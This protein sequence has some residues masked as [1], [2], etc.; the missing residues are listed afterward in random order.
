MSDTPELV[1]FNIKLD[2]T[3]RT[4][5][6]AIAKYNDTD[7][8]KLVRQFMKKYVSDNANLVRKV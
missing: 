6:K 8:S 7:S 3:L 1:V 2:K 5:F 4:R